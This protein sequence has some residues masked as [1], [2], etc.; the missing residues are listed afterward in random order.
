MIRFAR[1]NIP[2]PERGQ[3]GGRV[4]RDPVWLAA[5]KASGCPS[6][7]LHAL[8]RS[9][10]GRTILEWIIAFSL[11]LVLC[12]LAL[13]ESDVG[14][15]LAS[16][17]GVTDPAARQILAQPT[18]S[19]AL[20][21]LRLAGSRRAYEF[22]LDHPVLAVQLARR[23]HPPMQ[24]YT[25]TLVAEGQYQVEAL[26]ALRGMA[27]LI[28]T[29]PGQRAYRLEG[30]FHSLANFLRFSGRMVATLDYR[31]RRDRNSVSMETDS[32]I[33][34]RIDNVV[35]GMMTKLLTP[36]VIRLID[37][38]VEML[39]EGGRIVLAR[40]TDDPGGLY[41]EMTQWSEVK[42]DDLVLFR[43]TF[44][45]LPVKSRRPR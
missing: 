16:P 11:L 7:S 3:E 45:P 1:S 14:R 23:L 28:V 32:V 38:R 22:L 43:Q 44:L 42:P 29:R 25:V 17:A 40:V 4:V 37:R 18:L 12:G 39:A 21:Q 6:R 33:Y 10:A 31:E 36:L 35:L 41:R 26:G 5:G 34:L 9:W 27:Q 24:R 13:A 19:H 15:P 20:P 30:E 2:G 8:P